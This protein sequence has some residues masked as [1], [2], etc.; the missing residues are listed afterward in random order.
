MFNTLNLSF[1]VN[2]VKFEN[3]SLRRQWKIKQEKLSPKH[4]IIVNEVIELKL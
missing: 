4:P 2:K 3:Q 1:G